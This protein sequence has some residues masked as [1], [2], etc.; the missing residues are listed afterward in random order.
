M[1]AFSPPMYTLNLNI[2]IIPI[3]LVKYINAF[4]AYNFENCLSRNKNMIAEIPDAT[5][6]KDTNTKPKKGIPNM[7][8]S[9]TSK[10]KAMI[11]IF[12]NLNDFSLGLNIAISL[13]RI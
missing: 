3:K 5:T 2:P 1:F 13:L 4:I 8:A 10:Q 11:A 6:K 12:L 9:K 7:N